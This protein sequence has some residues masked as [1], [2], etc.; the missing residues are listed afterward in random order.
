M[1]IKAW[2]VKAIHVAY[3]EINHKRYDRRCRTGID[4]V[5]VFW[6]LVKEAARKARNI[7]SGWTLK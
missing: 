2:I 1:V 7:F 4:R 6:S 3:G 5:D